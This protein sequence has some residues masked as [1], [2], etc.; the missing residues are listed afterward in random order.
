M[1]LGLVTKLDKKNTATLKK[2]DDNVML[3]SCDVN[4]FFSNLW[5]IWSNLEAE[6]RMYGL[7]NLHFL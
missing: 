5:L 7:Q 3:G 4:V 2:I 6:F 1:K